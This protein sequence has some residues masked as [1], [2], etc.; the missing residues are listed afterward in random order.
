MANGR[1]SGISLCEVLNH[2]AKEGHVPKDFPSISTRDSMIENEKENKTSLYSSSSSSSSIPSTVDKNIPE[3]SITSSTDN[4]A[5][6]AHSTNEVLDRIENL[7][8][9]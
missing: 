2:L 5:S 4:D 1:L 6:T 7:D 3:H 9:K 8:C